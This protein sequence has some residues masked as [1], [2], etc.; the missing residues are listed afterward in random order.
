MSYSTT[1]VIN[2]P[3]IA[4]YDTFESIYDT[5]FS[6]I[7]NYARYKVGNE[8]DA[9]DVTA[10]TFERVFRNLHR[11]QPTKAPFSS[12]IFSIASNELKK[13]YR[14]QCRHKWLSF[15]QAG[16][17]LSNL[18]DPEDKA[19][20][21][22]TY[23]HLYEAL[24]CLKEREKNII[25]LKFGGQLTNREI[26]KMLNLSDSNVGVILYRSIQKLKKELEI[27]KVTL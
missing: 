11:Y 21:K 12:W 15:D 25:S 1:Q 24:S 7:L 2:K 17:L 23:K 5:Y 6:R 27:R 26:G 20:E 13:N 18:A 8:E 3:L 16:S 19:I 4:H 14:E 9:H 22:E 10:K